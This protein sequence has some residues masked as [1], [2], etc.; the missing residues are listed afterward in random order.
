[1]DNDIPEPFDIP[2][3]EEFYVYPTGKDKVG[4]NDPCICG[5]GKKLKK[6]CG[7]P[8]LQR[9]AQLISEINQELNN[10]KNAE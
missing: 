7:E 3:L 2:L 8:D 10:K 1:M 6:C 9:Y 4:R 5:S